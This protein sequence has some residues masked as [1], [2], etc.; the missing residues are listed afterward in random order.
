MV[1]EVLDTEGSVERSVR[2]RVTAT[3]RKLREI[4]GL[5]TKKDIP[6]RYRGRVY[7]ASVRAVLLYGTESWLMTE[8]PSD[9][10]ELRP[11]DAPI[12][13]GGFL[14]GTSEQRTTG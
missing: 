11:K 9:S 7:D 8:S 14:A 3:W 1:K 2:M 5:L 4:L 12:H 10:Y 13:G 6:P